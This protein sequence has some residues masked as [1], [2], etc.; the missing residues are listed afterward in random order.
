MIRLTFVLLGFLP[1]LVYGDIN[2]YI[3]PQGNYTVNTQRS[4]TY[5]L[6]PKTGTLP[7][8]INP[9]TSGTHTYITPNG[10]YMSIPN[11]NNTT[12]IQTSGARK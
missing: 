12:V 8:A 9:S 6:G 2:T 7:I 3:T 5:I 10:T 11:G 1:L 4:T